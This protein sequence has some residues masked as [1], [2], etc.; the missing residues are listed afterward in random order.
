M[1]YSD[2]C[3]VDFTLVGP[4]DPR[5]GREG[6][7]R[8]RVERVARGSSRSFFAFFRLFFRRRGARRGRCGRRQSADDDWRAYPARWTTYASVA[9]T[10]AAWC[11]LHATRQ[12][13]LVT[14][15]VHS[16]HTR[17]SPHRPLIAHTPRWSTPCDTISKN[18]ITIADPL[19]ESF[20]GRAP[21]AGTM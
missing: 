5:E 2:N 16:T 19:R 10:R 11:T 4:S 3:T 18:D 9:V 15:L 21:G 13:E 17:Y 6:G 14:V 20:E 12:C 8:G 1:S 7:S